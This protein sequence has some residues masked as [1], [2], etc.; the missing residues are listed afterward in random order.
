MADDKRIYD[1][2][3]ATDT[4][5]K[6][7]MVDTPSATDATFTPVPYHTVTTLP[8]SPISE[9]LY[10][11]TATDNFAPKGL[12]VY[13]NG[14]VCKTCLETLVLPNMEYNVN[15][16]LYTGV[17]YVTTLTAPVTYFNITLP[18]DGICR[19]LINNPSEYSIDGI[20]G[21]YKTTEFGLD[22]FTSGASSI[23]LTVQRDSIFGVASNE[24]ATV[25]RVIV[26]PVIVEPPLPG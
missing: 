22:A 12:Y 19:I 25:G 16:S 21:G 10:Y 7:I 9:C 14:W 23:R 2:D 8:A 24:Y 18:T 5:G 15:L 20:S 1:L 3:T 4:Q 26:E 13:N 17:S 6:L 11:L